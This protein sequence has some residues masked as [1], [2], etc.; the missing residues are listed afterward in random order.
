MAET[1]DGLPVQEV[2]EAELAEAIAKG[3][4]VPALPQFGDLSLDD[5]N[6]IGGEQLLLKAHVK[7]LTVAL[8]EA[9]R[10]IAALTPPATAPEAGG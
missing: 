7:R 6:A 1:K 5:I 3:E 9:H 4:V 2:G 8:A 10:Q